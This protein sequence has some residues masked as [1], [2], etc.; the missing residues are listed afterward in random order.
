[1][2]AG[3]EGFL[4]KGRIGADLIAAVETVLRGDRYFSRDVEKNM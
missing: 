1:M 3:A 4:A 2:V